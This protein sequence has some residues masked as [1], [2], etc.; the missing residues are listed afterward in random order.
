MTAA[1]IIGGT[2]RRLDGWKPTG[3]KF[4]A[5][6][7]S[8]DVASLRAAHTIATVPTDYDQG[9]L[10]SC[11]PNSIAEIFQHFLGEKCSRLFLY[12]WTRATESDTAGDDGVTIPDLV[13]VASAMGMPLEDVWPYD[14]ARFADAPPLPA[15]AEAI[16]RR[17]VQQDVIADLDHLLYELDR[18]QPVT[19][20]FGV[21]SSL[22][23]GEGAAA[24]TGIV[25]VPSTADPRAGGHCVNAIGFDR[26]RELV[27]CT[28]HWGSSFGDHGTILL[29]F[30]HWSAGN[31]MDMRAIRRVAR[32]P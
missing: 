5:A 15:L 19:L 29:P 22:E 13:D 10:N 14:V 25:A 31:V 6:R 17:I 30:A 11:G 9:Q 18:D 20:G 23:D 27:R 26:A 8:F 32:F 21:P 3:R 1:L 2:P 16:H 12:Y 28:S 24:T 7:P 4:G